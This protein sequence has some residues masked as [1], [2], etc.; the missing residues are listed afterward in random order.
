MVSDSQTGGQKE[1]PRYTELFGDPNPTKSDSRTS[2]GDAV[3]NATR[4][5]SKSA[6][7]VASKQAREDYKARGGGKKTKA[8]A[9]WWF[10]RITHRS[11]QK[12]GTAAQGPFPSKLSAQT[13]GFDNGLLKKKPTIQKRADAGDQGQVR[14]ALLG[15]EARGAKRVQTNVWR[16]FVDK[17]GKQT[18]A[19]KQSL[20]A[21]AGVGKLYTNAQKAAVT[22]EKSSSTRAASGKTT[23]QP[24]QGELQ[25]AASDARGR[26]AT[27]ATVDKVMSASGRS[28]AQKMATLN[29]QKSA[30]GAAND[31]VICV[32]AFEILPDGSPGPK[33]AYN[34]K[35]VAILRSNGQLTSSATG[36]A[37]AY[38]AATG[39]P[40]K[41][42]DLTDAD[43]R[44]LVKAAV[45]NRYYK[46][47]FGTSNKSKCA[48]RGASTGID[49]L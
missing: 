46:Q 19:Y 23:R 22:A 16:V 41:A 36:I 12:R 33:L 39:N 42:K 43:V 18:A 13:W 38:S 30:Q 5:G 17:E 35:P 6:A 20:L 26:G 8:T 34:A 1:N 32:K 49:K 25:Q 44:R 9:D 15:T 29:L 14:W 28:N 40:V 21:G 48:M 24:S 3:A 4:Y 37:V 2:I 7:D 10:D 47:S 45:A 31:A 27:Q 11:S